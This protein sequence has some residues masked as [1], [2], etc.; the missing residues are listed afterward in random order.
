M[1]K[2]I[3]F[4]WYETLSFSKQWGHLQSE[5][6]DL[7]NTIQYHIFEK[8]QNITNA[9]MHGNIRFLTITYFLL[10]HGISRDV[11]LNEF[12]R[13]LTFQQLATPEFIPMLKKLKEKGYQLIIATDHFDIFGTYLYPYLKLNELFDGYICSAEEGFLKNDID[14]NGNY[15]FFL[16]Y[17]KKHKLSYKDCVLIDNSKA[18]TDLYRKLGMQ[19]YC[20]QTPLDVL[21][22]ADDLLK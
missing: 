1:K 18:T 10:E 21:N 4:D 17:L 3:F 20:I 12:I 13:S 22:A 5:N 14:K 16:N 15:P 9:W 7:F 8:N 11:T 19:T 6:P 2:V